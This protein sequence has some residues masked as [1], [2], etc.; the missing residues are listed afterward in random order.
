LTINTKRFHYTLGVFPSVQVKWLRRNMMFA[1][2]PKMTWNSVLGKAIRSDAKRGTGRPPC[3]NTTFS[4]LEMCPEKE[5][6]HFG[7]R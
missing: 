6:P 3:L 5:A 7:N 1:K 4:N 2:G